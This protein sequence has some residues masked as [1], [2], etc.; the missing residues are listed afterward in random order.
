MAIGRRTFCSGVAGLML[1]A[2]ACAGAQNAP[3]APNAIKF[4]EAIKKWQPGKGPLLVTLDSPAC[5][6]GCAGYKVT[7]TGDGKVTY[8]GR[9]HVLVTGEHSGK[10]TRAQVEELAAAVRESNFATLGHPAAGISRFTLTVEAGGEKADASGESLL[11]PVSGPGSG[12]GNVLGRLATSVIEISGAQR[13]TIGNAET[14]PALQAEGWDF[15]SADPQ[16]V[17]LLVAASS[18]GNLALVKQ[19]LALGAPVNARGLMGALPLFAAIDGHHADVVQALLAAGRQTLKSVGANL[20]NERISA[21][22]R[23]RGPVSK[24]QT[25]DAGKLWRRKGSFPFASSG[26]IR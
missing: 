2:M 8:T 20:A 22:L 16:H 14:I 6:E 17:A 7:I 9:D 5:E 3:A 1:A 11:A 24:S 18:E 10:V 4:N 13:W 19:L 25:E 23:Y 12:A 21:M 15:K 26:P